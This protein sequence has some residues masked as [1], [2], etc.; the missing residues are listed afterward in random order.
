MEQ[1]TV[2]APATTPQAEDFQ[3]EREYHERKAREG[4]KEFFEKIQHILRM[5]EYLAPYKIEIA[6]FRGETAAKITSFGKV[7]CYFI[8]GKG[9]FSPDGKR[10]TDG[11]LANV[12]DTD[13]AMRRIRDYCSNTYEHLNSTNV[14]VDFAIMELCVTGLT[15]LVR[16]ETHSCFTTES[17]ANA[18]EHQWEKVWEHFADTF[19]WLKRK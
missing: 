16:G 10:R 3:A 17:L 1:T 18:I 7:D 8:P 6:D 5:K 4:A 2:T 9:A 12:T 15:A 19:Q 13:E 14:E 11:I